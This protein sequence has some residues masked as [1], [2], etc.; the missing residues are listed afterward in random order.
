MERLC[1]II[2]VADTVSELEEMIQS[3]RQLMDKLTAECRTLT[4]K[5]EESSL[6]HK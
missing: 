2:F 5:L 4:S 3:Q 1:I 6:N